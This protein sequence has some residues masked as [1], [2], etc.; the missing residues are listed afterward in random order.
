MWRLLIWSLILLLLVIFDDFS[1]CASENKR[2]LG[3]KRLSEISQLDEMSKS[4]RIVNIRLED[5]SLNDTREQLP[6]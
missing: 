1:L 3:L 4:G 6:N 2:D 5:F